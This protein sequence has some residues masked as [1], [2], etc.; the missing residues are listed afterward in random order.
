MN[1]HTIH[2]NGQ[3]T[4]EGIDM[5][6][7]CL[8]ISIRDYLR[9]CRNEEHSIIAIKEMAGLGAESDYA[10]ADWDNQMF[11]QAIETIAEVLDIRLEFYPVYL[12][13]HYSSRALR[14]ARHI[15]N[16]HSQNL[17][18]IAFYGAHF[19]FIVEGPGIQRC[20]FINVRQQPNIGVFKPD[21]TVVKPELVDEESETFKQT[22][23]M[24]VANKN[25]M[26][27]NEESI[28]LLRE[29]CE[30][31]IEETERYEKTNVQKSHTLTYQQEIIQFRENFDALNGRRKELINENKKLKE[32]NDSFNYI[33][34]M[35]L[36]K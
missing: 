35:L 19:E 16:E 10:M 29:E 22:F 36:E 13:E 4:E 12:E 3:V 5:V 1:Y 15:V 31:I 7:Q 32:E 14:D 9:Y 28:K 2:N 23:D 8:W 25:R 27:R 18:P 11:R 26:G 6:N 34:S 33:I 30:K 24:I 20:R 17:V 21:I